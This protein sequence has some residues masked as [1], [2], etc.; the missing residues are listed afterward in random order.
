MVIR[1]MAD[2]GR[3]AGRDAAATAATEMQTSPFAAPLPSTM[4]NWLLPVDAW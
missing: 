3:H 1:A 4:G 2:A